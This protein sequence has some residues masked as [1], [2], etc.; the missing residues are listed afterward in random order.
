MAA[1]L[2]FSH[3]CLGLNVMH[4]K[5]YDDKVIESKEVHGSTSLG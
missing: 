1:A 2:N 4:T 5:M 3:E